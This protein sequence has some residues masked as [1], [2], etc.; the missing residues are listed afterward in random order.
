MPPLSCFTLAVALEDMCHEKKRESRKA[1]LAAPANKHCD[2]CA[3]EEA[4][5]RG[6]QRAR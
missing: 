4:R 3:Q 2:A 6:L 5:A 1:Y